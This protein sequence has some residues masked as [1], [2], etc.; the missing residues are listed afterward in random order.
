MTIFHKTVSPKRLERHLHKLNGIL[1]LELVQEKFIELQELVPLDVLDL[2]LSTNVLQFRDSLREFQVN[3]GVH[4][5][6]DALRLH[7]LRL[8]YILHFA[9][10]SR[11][12][13]KLAVNQTIFNLYLSIDL[14]IKTYYG[15]LGFWGFG[16]LGVC[17]LFPFYNR[18]LVLHSC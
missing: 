9:A 12:S 8:M 2:L 10:F 4:S 17:M 15:V 3:E 5:V 14:L 16:V 18:L 1:V 13:F 7:I 6:E 11:H